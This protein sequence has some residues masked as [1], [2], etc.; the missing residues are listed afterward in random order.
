MLIFLKKY[1]LNL[2]FTLLGIIFIAQFQT[3]SLFSWQVFV[4]GFILYSLLSMITG[5]RFFSLLYLTQNIT[6][7]P[8]EIISIPARMNLFSYILPFKGGGMWL[9]WYLKKQYDLSFGKSIGLAFQN[10]LLALCLILMFVVNYQWPQKSLN[11]LVLTVALLIFLNTALIL[12]RRWMKQFISLRAI[13]YDIALSIFYL[14]VICTLPLLLSDIEMEQA[15]KFSALILTSS[16]IK[17]TPGNVGVL[18]GLAM[19]ASTW[20]QDPGFLEFVAFFRLLSLTHAAT[21]G[22]GAVLLDRKMLP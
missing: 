14:C 18:E 1:G 7:K 11:I 5:V 2:A 19:I 6:L 12:I 21:L 15:L 3:V 22:V 17:L 13:A 16:L 9:L 20:L 8:I 4:P 10:A